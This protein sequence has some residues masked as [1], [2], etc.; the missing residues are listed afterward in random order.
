MTNSQFDRDFGSTERFIKIMMRVIIVSVPVIFLTGILLVGWV[1][2]NVHEHGLKGA[3]QRLWDGPT[4]S[5]T[6]LK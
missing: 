6:V 4:N 2:V 5:V 1:G 3:I